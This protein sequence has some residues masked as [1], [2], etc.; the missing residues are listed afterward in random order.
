[1][2]LYN[3]T[4]KHLYKDERTKHKEQAKI[5][6]QKYDRGLTASIGKYKNGVLHISK[7]D[8][9]ARTVSS[10]RTGS[11]GNKVFNAMGG[12]HRKSGGS[13]RSK[14]KK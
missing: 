2:G 5:K 4:T 3:A 12:D 9:Q 7:R 11:V 1:M 8:I 10:K 14:K 6:S 13:K